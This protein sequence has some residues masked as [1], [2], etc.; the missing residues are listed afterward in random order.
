LAA[1]APANALALATIG[2]E[3]TL[4]SRFGLY[5]AQGMVSIQL[6]VPLTEAMARLRAHT[7]A[8]DRTL[9]AE[10]RDIVTRT[11]SLQADNR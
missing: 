11:L 3:H 5:Q 10:A 8:H 4:E 7:Y 6:G 1:D 2:V 9:G